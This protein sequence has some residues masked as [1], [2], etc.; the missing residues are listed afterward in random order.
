MFSHFV[1]QDRVLKNDEII[2]N[3]VRDVFSA[4]SHQSRD[5]S[6]SVETCKGSHLF[7]AKELIRTSH[8]RDCDE[9]QQCSP[10]TVF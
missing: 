3:P 4:N 5:L 1:N 2:I 9:K 7:K 6:S 8:S 10:S